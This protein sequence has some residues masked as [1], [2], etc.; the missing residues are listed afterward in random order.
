M[1]KPQ[2]TKPSPPAKPE[3]KARK[4]ES[5]PIRLATPAPRPP[6]PL[7][8]PVAPSTAALDLFQRG[9]E[10]MQRHEYQS[11]AALFRELLDQHPNERALLDRVRVYLDLC[12]RE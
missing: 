10:G 11:A 8:T 7:P 9:M 12:E 2:R 4:P 6:P 5:A 3:K 1:A